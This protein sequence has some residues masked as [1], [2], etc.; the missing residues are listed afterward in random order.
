M[1]SK[2][3]TDCTASSRL[4]RGTRGALPWMSYWLIMLLSFELTALL[5]GAA[6]INARAAYLMSVGNMTIVGFME[7][8]LPRNPR[9]NLLR[10][11]QSWNDIAHLLFFKLTIRPLAWGV[12]IFVVVTANHWHWSTG[13]WSR[14]L[15][16]L[17]VIVQFVTLL[18][19]FDLI[20]YGYHRSL[21]RIDCLFRFHAIHHDTRQVHLLKAVRVHFVE[22][23]I[24]FLV[25]VSPFLLMGCPTPLLIWLGMWNVF[26]SNLAHSNVDQRFVWWIHYIVRTVDVHY[27]HHAE[28]VVLQNSNFG[29]LPIWDLVFGTYRHPQHNPVAATGIKGDPVPPDFV[30][31]LLFPFRAEI[32]SRKSHP[33]VDVCPRDLSSRAG[34]TIR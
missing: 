14:Y 21:H 24:N 18:L 30:G 5:A 3:L 17:P 9:T 22:E 16:N 34:G 27:I 1:V 20:G 11:R 7:W 25:E 23:F 29:G 32:Y 10:D 19:L 26:E 4:I 12:T 31:Q 2:A 13:I 33:K 15:A 8:L 28:E 6:P